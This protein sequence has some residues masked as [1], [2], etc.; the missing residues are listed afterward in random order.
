VNWNHELFVGDYDGSGR[1]PWDGK[2]DEVRYY[3]RILSDDEIFNVF[4]NEEGHLLSVNT[5]D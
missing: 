2:L 5:N 4:V 1:W 3:N